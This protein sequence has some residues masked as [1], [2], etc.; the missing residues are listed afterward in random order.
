MTVGFTSPS[1]TTPESA[2]LVPVTV[3]LS[4]SDGGAAA[5][6]G[7]VRYAT[8]D[9]TAT[10][11]NDYAA[12]TG[13]LMWLAG[14]PNRTA[15]T[16]DVPVMNDTLNEGNE[17]FIMAL[18]AATNAVVG[19]SQHTVTILDDDP[20]PTPGDPAIVMQPAGQTVHFGQPATLIVVAT[21]TPPLSYRWYEGAAGDTRSPI[22]TATQSSFTSPPLTRDTQYWVR[23]SSPFG[24]VDSIAVPVVV[25][26][27][28]TVAK[29]PRSR[30]I[31]SGQTATL[32]VDATGTAPLSY[33]WYAGSSGDAGN[34]IGG[35]TASSYTT[36]PLTGTATYW[37]RIS[38]DLGSADSVSATITVGM[39]SN[40]NIAFTSTRAGNQ[41]IYV[42]NSDGTSLVNLTDN[43]ADDSSPAW[44]PDGTRIAFV[45]TRAGV[46][47]IHLMNADGAQQTNCTPGTVPSTLPAWSPDGTKI[48]FTR[49]GN[50][51][52]TDSDV[53][54][55]NASDCGVL[56]PAAPKPLAANHPD[57][58]E[59]AV[60]SPDGDRIVY[61]H[62]TY[63]RR[64][65]A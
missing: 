62:S 37:V 31:V 32:S 52:P 1:S 3:T 21:G 11:G 59:E 53:Y 44:S 50:V 2:C 8:S 65:S 26:V 7:S 18:R 9:G 29:E 28:P 46:P 43:P 20:V 23:V 12:K 45:S 47:Q 6:A 5:T 19:Q 33:Q 64:S 15:W 17:S 25:V 54:V 39:L 36:P 16:I 56:L 4:T 30:T 49:F 10:A 42:M 27:S 40:G 22:P 41:E 51:V 58:E 63:S 14:A 57:R 60:W 13:T 48:L 61:V 38:N 55:M 34:R 35:A 24:S